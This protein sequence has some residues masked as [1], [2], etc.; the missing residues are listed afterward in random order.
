MVEASSALTGAGAHGG[1]GTGV[2]LLS[3]AT[4]A[5]TVLGQVQMKASGFWSVN[6]S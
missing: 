6:G 4:D 1:S 5:H 2:G 3:E